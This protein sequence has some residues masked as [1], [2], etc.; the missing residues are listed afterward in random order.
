MAFKR[1]YPDPI[2]LSGEH[3]SGAKLYTRMA[4]CPLYV[5]VRV[6]G[7]AIPYSKRRSF[8]LGWDIE[9]ARWTAAKDRKLL[10][11]QFLEWAAGLIL[12]EYPNL[13]EATGMNAAE[14]AEEKADRAKRR[15][16]AQARR[17]GEA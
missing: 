17:K 7:P 1:T 11:D 15:A 9:N 3:S 10:P 14:I 8:W 2:T 13:A 12:D 16:A 6:I 5:S 4:D